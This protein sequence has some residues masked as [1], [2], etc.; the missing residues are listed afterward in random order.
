[1][2]NDVYQLITRGRL[3][4]EFWE[5]VQHYRSGVASASDPVTAASH[6]VAGYRAA[7]E[8][9]LADA[10]SMDAEVTGYSCKRVNNGGSP[11]VMVPIVPVQGTVNSQ[12]VNAATA[13][14]IV[15]EYAVDGRFRTGRWFIP[16]LPEDYEDGNSYTADAIAAAAAVI[17]ANAS[18]SNGGD[19][20]TWGVWGRTSGTFFSPSYA[21]L[22]SKLGIQRRRL[23]PVQ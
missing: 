23:L 7:V 8:S 22:S 14:L 10:Q 17:G 20:F 11:T 21:H 13:Y 12:S 6:L 15:S 4:G 19:T 18:F 1:M 3:N 5:T 16:G 9:T 2:A